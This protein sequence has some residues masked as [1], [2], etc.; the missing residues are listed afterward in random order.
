MTRISMAQ[1]MATK[2]RPIQYVIPGIIPEGLTILAAPPKVGKSWMV[3]DLAYQL[4]NGGTHR[5]GT[6]GSLPRA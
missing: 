4:A 1:L 3:L 2:F 6:P 5:S